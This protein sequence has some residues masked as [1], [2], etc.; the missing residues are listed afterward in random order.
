M[1]FISLNHERATKVSI[2]I[3]GI[4]RRKSEFHPPPDIHGNSTNHGVKYLGESKSIGDNHG[5][6]IT[7]FLIRCL[8]KSVE[9]KPKEADEGRKNKC[10]FPFL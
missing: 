3:R 7:S 2:I 10:S 5:I 8:K 1:A 9:P 4:M 6:A